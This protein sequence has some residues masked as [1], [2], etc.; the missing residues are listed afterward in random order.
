M[1]VWQSLRVLHDQG[2]SKSS[3]ARASKHATINKFSFP[4]LFIYHLPKRLILKTLFIPIFMILC[5]CG[6]SGDSES[7]LSKW[8]QIG[9]EEQAS[10]NLTQLPS[11]N[12][13]FA[14]TYDGVYK[15]N[16]K[17]LNWNK[18]YNGFTVFFAI[19]QDGTV[20]YTGYPINGTLSGKFL[21]ST[22]GGNFFE[23]LEP[24]G[25]GITSIVIDPRNK[26][27]AYLSAENN[28]T[29]SGGIYKTN[30]GGNSWNKVV[31][32]ESYTLA[33]SNDGKMIVAGTN[34]GILKSFDDGLTWESMEFGQRIRSVYLHPYNNS[35]VYI[36]AY[37]GGSTRIWK[38]VDS[39]MSWN[40][41]NKG[42]SE[43]IETLAI[44]SND[45][46]TIYAGGGLQGTSIGNN[47]FKS[48]DGGGS[49]TLMNEGIEGLMIYSIV[50]DRA[51]NHTLYAGTS[52]GVFKR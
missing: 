25:S 6:C 23:V 13:I 20:L 16:I 24:F 8:K 14:T 15:K 18:I 31:D 2:D 21:K 26:E 32:A 41:L 19:Y 5:L 39:G 42:I 37:D 9:L 22:D 51:D 47:F 33:I 3:R 52:R 40:P 4:L 35:I 45:P 38:T 48:V 34:V 27:A 12:S 11:N 44:D 10:F 28:G 29:F 46:Q 30:D 1:V 7:K 17:E 43:S 49:W 50:I 36:L